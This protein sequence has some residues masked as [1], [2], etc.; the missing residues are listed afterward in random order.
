[1]KCS[2]RTRAVSSSS[3]D[4]RSITWHQWQAAYPIES[5][6]GRSASRARASASSPHGYQSTGLSLCC[7]RY[8]DVS[9]AR[10]FGIPLKL[11]SPGCHYLQVRGGRDDSRVAGHVVT[12]GHAGQVVRE[13][14]LARLV[15]ARER[16]LRRAEPC[17]HVLEPELR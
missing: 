13:R 3:N 16:H 5:M 15:E 12:L 2:F 6:I 10:R 4:S 14:L 17:A 8:G 9:S 7:S 11:P 1:M